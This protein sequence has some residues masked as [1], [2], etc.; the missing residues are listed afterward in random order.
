MDQ[1]TT[2]YPK[3]EN[4]EL[5]GKANYLSDAL[6]CQPEKTDGTRDTRTIGRNAQP[7]KSK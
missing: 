7:D 3:A 5:A 4:S 2:F 6:R 1:K